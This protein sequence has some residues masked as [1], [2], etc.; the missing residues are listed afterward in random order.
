M[1]TVLSLLR[2]FDLV[3]DVHAVVSRLSAESAITQAQAMYPGHEDVW[4]KAF[5]ELD[6][7]NSGKVTEEEY[8]AKYGSESDPLVGLG[9]LYKDHFDQDGGAHFL[10]FSLWT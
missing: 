8:K 6:A 4:V 1:E 3:V 2:R 9:A 10:P 5:T 7:D